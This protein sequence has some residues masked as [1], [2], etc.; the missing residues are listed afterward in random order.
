MSQSGTFKN[1]FAEPIPVL[2]GHPES[3][4]SH[5][6]I[7]KGIECLQRTLL[8]QSWAIGSVAM[9]PAYSL[10]AQKA[11]K[12]MVPFFTADQS[13]KD[14]YKTYP[15]RGPNLLRR[16]FTFSSKIEFSAGYLQNFTKYGERWSD[17]YPELPNTPQEANEAREPLLKLGKLCLDIKKN[18]LNSIFN[19]LSNDNALNVEAAQNMLTDDLML[20]MV[21]YAP[22]AKK[23]LSPEES[24]HGWHVDPPPLGFMLGPTTENPGIYLWSALI[25]DFVPAPRLAEN[26]FI[27]HTGSKLG[28]AVIKERFPFFV[29]NYHYVEN[30]AHAQQH[31]RMALQFQG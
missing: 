24:L 27:I 28:E 21:Y 6:I 3:K 9:H 25:G 16:D 8:L 2:A 1:V 18:T 13:V 26:E 19:T 30:T 22:T 5:I 11:R 29:P 31:G 20:G 15:H 7:P 12:E 17:I 10:W 4:D 23:E 14:Q